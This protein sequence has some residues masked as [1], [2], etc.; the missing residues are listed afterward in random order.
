MS[1][2]AVRVVDAGLRQFAVVNGKRRERN[3]I[4]QIRV[5]EVGPGW[6]WSPHAK[7]LTWDGTRERHC[8]VVAHRCLP[9][10]CCYSGQCTPHCQSSS[11]S[12]FRAAA[13]QLGKLRGKGMEAANEER[14]RVFSGGEEVLALF[15]GCGDDS[16]GRLG[17]RTMNHTPGHHGAHVCHKC[18][19]TFPNP[20]PNAKHRR[21]HKKVCG[22]IEGFKI[23]ES[24]ESSDNNHL[25]VKKNELCDDDRQSPVGLMNDN[26]DEVERQVSNRSEDEVFADAVS[27]FKDAG[28]SAMAE[29]VAVGHPED[30]DNAKPVL[31]VLHT[32]IA[33]KSPQVSSPTC[34]DRFWSPEALS[35]SPEK[36]IQSAATLNETNK[37][38]AGLLLTEE[39]AAETKP[40]AN[41]SVVSM[42]V[43]KCE[44]IEVSKKEHMPT[45]V[46]ASSTHACSEM[47]CDA[48]GKDG[49]AT[50]E[51]HSDVSPVCAIRLATASLEGSFVGYLEDQPRSVGHEGIS[52]EPC[53]SQPTSTVFSSSQSGFIEVENFSQQ[54]EDCIEIHPKHGVDFEDKVSHGG[55][56]TED[57]PEIGSEHEVN[58]EDKFPDGGI[59]AQDYLQLGPKNAV[60]L[61]DKVSD[62]VSDIKSEL[63]KK[64]LD[65]VTSIAE[66][67]PETSRRLQ[68]SSDTQSELDKKALDSI[69]SIAEE[70]PER[71]LGMQKSLNVASSD[72]TALVDLAVVL[73]GPQVDSAEGGA[74]SQFVATDSHLQEDLGQIKPESPFISHSIEDAA[75]TSEGMTQV[76]S[77]RQVSVDEDTC[78]K[79]PLV[80]EVQGSVEPGVRVVSGALG[81]AIKADLGAT[82]LVHVQEGICKADRTSGNDVHD[83][84]VEYD[85]N[86]ATKDQ[87]DD[88]SEADSS[89]TARVLEDQKTSVECAASN[90]KTLPV[91]V[92]ENV[93]KVD[94]ALVKSLVEESVQGA[95]IYVSNDHIDKKEKADSGETSGR[96][97]DE[98]G[99][100]DIECVQLSKGA[101][102][103][104]LKE[105]VSKVD[106]TIGKSVTVESVSSNQSSI[107]KD[108]MD[109][110]SEVD[111]IVTSE[112]AIDNEETAV[113]N[114]CVGSSEL[115]AEVHEV[116]GDRGMAISD[117]L[118]GAVRDTDT[119]QA[120]ERNLL[121][122]AVKHMVAEQPFEIGIENDEENKSMK[123]EVCVG[124]VGPRETEVPSTEQIQ[125]HVG[126]VG[127]I[128]GSIMWEGSLRNDHS[129]SNKDYLSENMTS[130][131]NNTTGRTSNENETMVPAEYIGSTD[132]GSELHDAVHQKPQSE[133]GDSV[134]GAPVSGGDEDKSVLSERNTSS[135]FVVEGSG[136]EDKCHRDVGAGEAKLNLQPND[137]IPLETITSSEGASSSSCFLSNV[138]GP[139]ARQHQLEDVSLENLR[140]VTFGNSTEPSVIEPGV[141]LEDRKTEEV[142]ASK[143]HSD[144]GV[145]TAV[146]EDISE[147]IRFSPEGHHDAILK[148]NANASVVVSDASVDSMSQVDSVE[149]TW[150]S[151]SGSNLEMP[152]EE[153]S[154]ASIRTE[155]NS[156][157]GQLDNNDVFEPPSF[158]TLV[159]PQQDEEKQGAS[160][161]TEIQL[162]ENS[163]KPTSPPSQAGWFPSVVHGSNESPRRKKN[164]E[165]I[166]K[167]VN[168]SSGKP[169]TPLR[170]LLV[171]ASA[172]KKHYQQI[173]T[174]R[175]QEPAPQ[176]HDDN[177]TG[178]PN[179]ELAGEQKPN[180]KGVM[181]T[182]WNSP[183]RLPISKREKRK[184]RGKAYWVP[185]V[186]CSSVS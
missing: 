25:L 182:E 44:N 87:T 4:I 39:C 59:L 112:S 66:E 89:A 167:V 22:K 146:T 137:D 19:W 166:A 96:G 35:S 151:I 85:Q 64:A 77:H 153:P 84:S 150:G 12:T 71:S 152:K 186:C 139:C 140:E 130:N 18:G 101:A 45:A 32:P 109:D 116:S 42:N 121:D 23:L 53:I 61:E 105:D 106:G 123:S 143:V 129:T 82:V 122:S 31:E 92:E 103:V 165:I 83:E 33:N 118:H 9:E 7:R 43:E 14:E 65:F 88:K 27:D 107:E 174:S 91:I 20:H 48:N 24:E 8:F 56:L 117:F 111:L 55:I 120:P 90:D 99:A 40:F 21:A 50:T 70:S 95:Q 168:W 78:K 54:S 185:F 172:E 125:G 62:G 93:R 72:S 47:G 3:Q 6:G 69:T 63:D 184:V 135:E 158:M 145:Q 30:T 155:N 100:T 81:E 132:L 178:K 110:K 136:T 57:L 36:R 13:A 2:E 164:E 114:G 15:I 144:S 79:K 170:S 147:E 169:H 126:E 51:V 52:T 104:Q 26:K 74:V 159:D 102:F 157:K 10:Q 17:E 171:E 124:I 58:P 76:D 38:S 115:N 177:S 156:D 131:L 149:G 49:C 154:A 1:G 75:Q 86:S 142:V 46:T 128:T 5:K 68:K 113:G 34:D 175:E 141:Q 94:G 11:S 133:I 29:P 119:A 67:S 183:A 176:E 163:H 97:T 98:K 180:I 160:S 179:S 134:V 80:C 162:A 28:S 138:S 173:Q 73:E 181:E 161:S 37:V 41:V 16:R 108:H 148:N 127:E 60:D